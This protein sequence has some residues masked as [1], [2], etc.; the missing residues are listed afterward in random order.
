MAANPYHPFVSSFAGI[1]REGKS[2]PLGGIPAP[3]KSGHKPDAPVVIIFSPHPDDECVVGGLP[4]RL[5]REGGMRI[6][7]IAV[8]L[9]SK[10]E[11]RQA[12][13][14][15]LKSACDWLG[16]ELEHIAP[17]GLERI[18]LKTRTEDPKH[19]AG[20]VK[21]VA[22]S[23]ACLQPSTIF[24]PHEGDGNTTHIGTHFLLMD[25]LKTMP[26]NFQ[27]LMVE[28]EFWAPMPRPNLMVESSMDDVADLVAALSFHAGEVQRNPYHLRLPA[29]LLDNV[30]R[31][32]ESVGGQGNV[33]PDFMFATLYRL[34]SW[35][36]G[37][38]EQ[39]LEG[40]KQIGAGQK[41][42]GNFPGMV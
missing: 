22:A 24:F 30:R 18:N 14:A 39:M 1:I 42:T 16:F 6:I 4:L 3:A 10:T 33:A 12:R 2:L 25:A 9:G 31:G 21:S 29:M 8:T 28:T 26:V 13:L 34:S 40:G 17:E 35:K 41:V 11:R 5:M 7:N 15:E 19:W 38:I 37:R 23:V 27:C 20:A 36:K 32:T